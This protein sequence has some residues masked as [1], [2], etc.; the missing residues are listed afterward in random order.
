MHPKSLAKIQAKLAVN[1]PGDIYE[2]EADRI[3]DQVMMATPA[4]TAVSGAPPRIQRFVGQLSRQM[5]AA[6]ASVNRVLASSGRP[7]D[8]ALRQDMEQRFGYDFSRVRVHSDAKAA[9]SA[10]A[11]NAR[12]YTVGHDIVFGAGQYRPGSDTG[13]HLLSHELTHTIQQHGDAVRVQRQCVASP[14]P[15]ILVPIDALFPRY[16]AAEKCIQTM[17][18]S[19]HPAKPGISLSYNAEWLH[20]TGGLA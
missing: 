18:A 19:S 16:D 17:Y 15:P 10:R 7:M 8:S 20:L 1:T 2:Q 5:D 3:A 4:Y 11:V 9:E 13:R 6:P 14:C 12:A